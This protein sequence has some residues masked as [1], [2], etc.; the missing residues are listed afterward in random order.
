M[1]IEELYQQYKSKM[2]RVADVKNALAVLQWDQET[3]LPAKGAALRAEQMAT[4]SEIA[5][6]MFADAEL[7]GILKTLSET[8]N[9]SFSQQ[10]NVELTLEDFNKNKK[11]SAAFVRK[12]SEATSRSYHSWIDA[13]KQNNFSL[14]KKDLKAL[15]ELKREEAHILGF[16]NHPYDALLNEYEKGATVAWL[17]GIFNTLQK[18][19]KELLDA[20]M[21][22]TQ[23]NNDFLQ[24]HFD[25]DK[26]WAFGLDILKKIGYDFEAGRQDI[27]AHPFT[28][29]FNAHDVRIT[30]RID[31]NDFSSMTWSCI[32][33]GGHALYE[34]GLPIESYGLP[35]GEFCSLGIH[36]SQSRL[37]ENCI[38]RS[39]GFIEGNFSLMQQYFPGL[40]EVTPAELY[41]A[42]N[43]VQ[44]SLIRTEADELTY[45][46]HVMIRY[47]VEKKLIEGNLS[48]EDIPAFWNEM[49]KQYLGVKVPDDAQGCLQ[50]IHWSHGSFGYFP[51]YSLGSL[52]AAQFLSYIEK[53]HQDL[54]L[55]ITA[56][57]YTG[58]HQWLK[59]NVYQYG[60]LY[61]SEELCNKATGE[62]LQ[63]QY[64]MEYL[65]HKYA[66]IYQLRK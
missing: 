63:L 53:Q 64:F 57:N 24:Q 27:S 59:A 33:E 26:Q 46:F 16:E 19:L 2:R 13:R 6:E 8:N 39:L 61:S 49:Y 20:I 40:Q 65:F 48:A 9:L 30:T 14:F 47:D 32:H 58:I 4:L 28:T 41:R 35:A 50:D 18:P 11:Y 60:R 62:P 54:Q 15:V 66:E 56:G 31:E 51:T 23:P 12:L 44:P 3:Y 25:K 45:H 37:W 36:E 22:K 43:K 10:K 1:Q 34:Q 42:L 21:Q 52:Y 29:S 17:D 55:Q 7:E 5:H 38:G